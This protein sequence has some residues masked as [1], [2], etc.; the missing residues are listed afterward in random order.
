M[1]TPAKPAVSQPAMKSASSGSGRPTGTRRS[2]RTSA[3][4]QRAELR[5]VE[6]HLEDADPERPQG[7]LDRVADGGGP[8]DGAALPHALDPERIARRWTLQVPQLDARHIRRRRQRVL[9]QGAGEELARVVVD[10]RL[11]EPAA[12]PLGDAA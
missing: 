5:R 8:R 3:S 4:E 6:R 12:D 2:I 9:H 11:A 10:E 1:P 7:V